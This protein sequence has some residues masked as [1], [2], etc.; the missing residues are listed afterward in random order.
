MDLS[1]FFAGFLAGPAFEMQE[2]LS[3]T[4]LEVFNDKHAKGKIP[5]TIIPALIKLGSSLILFCGVILSGYYS[6]DWMFT[7]D[8]D[9][10]FFINRYLYMGFSVSLVRYK[11]YFGWKIAEGGANACGLGY[12][13]VDDKG[14]Y[15]W[16]R[17]SNANVLKVEIPENMSAITGNWNIATAKWLK[18]HVY[19]RVTPPG[20]KPSFFSTMCVYIVSAIWH[21]FYPGYYNTFGLGAV[22]TE[23]SH[24]FRRHVRPMFLTAD[25]KP[26]PTKI[27][28][29]IFS[30]IVSWT[31]INY[32]GLSF[33]LL[34]FNRSVQLYTK[35][36]FIVHILSPLILAFY[37]V[38]GAGSKHVSR[39]KPAVTSNGGSRANGSKI[40]TT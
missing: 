35:F 13:G 14:K 30:V 10:L 24:R 32:A 9:A 16:D 34:D 3:F 8:F 11:Y 22:M 17:I 39:N 27:F 23:I 5:S 29:D 15:K 38:T 12:N 2:Y 1:T 20:S 6:I 31:S 19:V 36:Y 7:R 25:D 4:N 26:K 21:G 18:R 28:Y 33:L 37:L 40:H